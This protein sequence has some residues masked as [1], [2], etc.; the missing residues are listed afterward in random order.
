MHA[1][2]R[3]GLI[4][5]F[6]AVV[7]C[8]RASAQ[9]LVYDDALRSGWE[10]WSW[11]TVSLNNANLAHEGAASIKVTAGAYQALY[12]HH[13][14][15]D[16]SAYTNLVFWIDGGSSG[17]QR[18][19][20]QATS[21]GNAQD[22]VQLPALVADSWTQVTISLQSLGVDADPAFDGFWI[23]DRS[24]ATQPAFFVDD[25]NL[26]AASGPPP[27]ITNSAVA[28]SLDASIV[29]GSISE[30]IYGVA[31]ASSNELKLLNVP[32]NRSGGNAESRYNWKINAHNRA[33]DYYFESIGDASGA[34]A[35]AESDQFVR[36]TMA[37]GAKAMLT[38]PMIGWGAK[39]GNNRAKLGSFSI[40]KYGAQTDRDPFFTDAGNGI[41]SSSPLQY[42]VGNDPNDANVPA[43]TLFQQEWVQHLTNLWGAAAGGGVGYYFLDNEPSIWFSTHRDVHP[44]GATMRE[45]REKSIQYATMLKSVQPGALVLGPEEWGWSGYFY[46]GYDQQYGSKFGWSNLPDRGTNG[47][48]DYLPWFLDQMR[49]QSAIQGERLLDVF[50]VH[51][52][53]QGGEFSDNTSSTM[54]LLR[55]RSTRSLW[56]PSYTDQSWINDKVHLIPRL[57]Q[58]VDQNYPGTRIG[59]TEYNWGAEKHINGATA[60]ADLLGI[61]GREGVDIATRWTTPDSATPAFKAIQMYRNYDGARSTFGQSSIPIAVPNPDNLSAFAAQRSDGALTVMVVNKQLSGS[62]PLTLSINHFSNSSVA[63]LYQLTGANVISKLPDLAIT[64]GVISNTLPSPSIS[65][66]VVE[67]AAPPASIQLVVKNITETNLTI[68]TQSAAGKRFVIEST[69]DFSSWKTLMTNSP[70]NSSETFVLPRAGSYQFYRALVQP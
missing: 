47:G 24:G 42:V 30:L 15:L 21:L 57:K 16:G 5:G 17:G 45:I 26:V 23:Q 68:S 50:T 55:N 38:V 61:F 33:A 9:G 36:D 64:A 54:Q 65:L 32:L 28:L 39:L 31:F 41:V 60:Q 6:I 59:I 10:N 14:A 48:A 52:Y 8:A 18:L 27:V 49:K 3:I 40:A 51:Y 63:H 43:D 19:Q 35:G 22:P 70:G 25:I 62:T 66:F 7:V 44:V 69:A 13:S 11:A 53:P 4:W 20:V 37:G 29:R 58:W 12:L 1:I 2:K 34:T 46:S 67:S 56:D